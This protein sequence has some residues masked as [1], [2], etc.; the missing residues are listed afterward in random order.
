MSSFQK[1]AADFTHIIGLGLKYSG[2]FAL[3]AMAVVGTVSID[4][5][6]LAYASKERNGFLTGLILGTLISNN[7]TPVNPLYLL[8]AS[9]ITSAIAVGLS[10]ALGVPGVGVAILI[11]WAVAAAVFAIGLGIV[12]LAEAIDPEPENQ[13]SCFSMS[14]A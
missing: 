5:V 2:G 9:P 12:A 14:C 7:N 8:I 13:P 11:G 4:I 1:G 10:F 6:L 3:L